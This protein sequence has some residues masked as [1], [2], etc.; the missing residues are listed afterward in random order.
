[1]TM[2]RQQTQKRLRSPI[3]LVLLGRP[4]GRP[5]ITSRNEREEKMALTERRMQVIA[6]PGA[7]RK[8]GQITSEGEK[9]TFVATLG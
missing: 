6:F 7:S 4:R 9:D 2:E 8:P 3:G 5:K 1:V